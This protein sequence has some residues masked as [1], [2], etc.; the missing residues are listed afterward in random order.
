MNNSILKE[1]VAARRAEGAAS[2]RTP[3]DTL[4]S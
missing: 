2:D 1:E 4:N 3:A